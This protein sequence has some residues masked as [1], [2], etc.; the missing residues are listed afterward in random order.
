MSVLLETSMGD[1]V[2]DLY[3]DKVPKN[4]LNF[5]KLCKLKYYNFSLV[6]TVERNFMMQVTDPL[7]NS[8]GGQSVHK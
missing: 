1:L 2:I 3:V 7:G 5:L 8:N 4:C 6:R